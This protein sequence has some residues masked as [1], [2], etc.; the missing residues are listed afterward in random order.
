MQEMPQAA[1]GA[2]RD[3]FN[4]KRDAVRLVTLLSPT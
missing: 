1:I 4:A 2:V 3:A